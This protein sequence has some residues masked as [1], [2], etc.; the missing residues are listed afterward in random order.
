MT[1]NDINITGI[2]NS[3]SYYFLNPIFLRIDSQSK[4]VTRATIQLTNYARLNATGESLQTNTFKVQSNPEGIIYIDIS[5]YIKT[6]AVSLNGYRSR[7]YN[8]NSPYSIN[9]MDVVIHVETREDS[10]PTRFLFYKFFVNGYSITQQTNR[11]VVSLNLSTNDDITDEEMNIPYFV[12]ESEIEKL[13]RTRYDRYEHNINPY[14][15]PASTINYS[16]YVHLKGCDNVYFR[17]LNSKGGYNH[18]AF[19]SFSISTNNETQ[20][21]KIKISDYAN[22]KVFKVPNKITHNREYTAVHEFDS[23][24]RPFIDEF[25]RSQYVQVLFDVGSEF[26][27]VDI[28]QNSVPSNNDESFELAYKFKL[29]NSINL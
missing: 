29:T 26:L 18:I 10:T 9:N 17:F 27:D 25:I 19:N 21:S 13:S 24:F 4:F 16:N 8:N 28:Q 20:D 3:D 7:Y 22:N 6:I 15:I 23:R 14:T 2:D 5:E 11:R 12:G 1:I